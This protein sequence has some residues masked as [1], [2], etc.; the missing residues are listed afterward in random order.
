M[1]GPISGPDAKVSYGPPWSAGDIL[2]F[3]VIDALD[4]CEDEDPD[5]SILLVLKQVISRRYSGL[6]CYFY[7]L[8]PIIWN[9]GLKVK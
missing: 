9:L 8:W 6:F 5:S 2:T 1:V 4:K 7:S 3:I